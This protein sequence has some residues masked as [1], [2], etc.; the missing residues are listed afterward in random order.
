MIDTGGYAE[1]LRQ[2]RPERR[3][4]FDHATTTGVV[5]S[6]GTPGPTSEPIDDIILAT[7]F[8]ESFPFLDPLPDAGDHH[9]GLSQ[10]VPGLAFVGRSGQNGLASATLRGSGRDAR[11]IVRTLNRWLDHNP[12]RCAPDSWQAPARTAG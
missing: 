6:D 12:P 3:P 7:G 2:N 8:T 11:F 9:R 1:R 4:M 10:C 5:W